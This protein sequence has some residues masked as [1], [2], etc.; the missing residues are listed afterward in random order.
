VTPEE[1]REVL[2]EALWTVG[3]G[4]PSKVSLDQAADLVESWI[5]EARADE[6]R[7]TIDSLATR[8]DKWADDAAEADDTQ[9][10][11]GLAV[12][13]RSAAHYARE[14]Q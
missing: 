13:W 5:V 9:R 7:N 10:G 11:S 3:Y 8:Y 12:A 2:G 1:R 14:E 4:A 6:R